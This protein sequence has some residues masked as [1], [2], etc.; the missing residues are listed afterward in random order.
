MMS[1][2]PTALAHA[3]FRDHFHACVF[4]TSSAEERE[5]IDPFFVEGMRQGGRAV[6]IVDPEH[7][8]QHETRLAAS[9]P[10]ADLLEVTTWHDAHLK[11]G[12]FDQERM[13]AALDQMLRDHAATGKP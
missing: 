12:S 8:A 1:S 6:Y 11:D 13:M 3:H 2:S 4:V 10:S 5:V 7:R 9:A